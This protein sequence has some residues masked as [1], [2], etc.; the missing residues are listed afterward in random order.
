[1]AVHKSPLILK[2]LVGNA[3]TYVRPLQCELDVTPTDETTDDV[4]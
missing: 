4:V 3:R 2:Q 1:M